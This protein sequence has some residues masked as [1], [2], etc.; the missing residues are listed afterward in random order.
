MRRDRL[1]GDPTWHLNTCECLADG[2]GGRR[3]ICESCQEREALSERRYLQRGQT[4]MERA[5]ALRACR[6]EAGRWARVSAAEFEHCRGAGAHSALY[7]WGRY[8]QRLWVLGLHRCAAYARSRVDGLD[9][10]AKLE[11]EDEVRKERKA[12]EGWITEW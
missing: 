3:L 11:R 1:N 8:A 9:Y 5:L 2:Q 12:L 4:S 6:R 7:A 10:A